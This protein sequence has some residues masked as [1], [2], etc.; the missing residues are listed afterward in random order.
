MI[1]LYQKIITISLGL[2][3][4]FW[5][6][7]TVFGAT[8]PAYVWVYQWKA[9]SGVNTPIQTSTFETEALC[10]ADLN[11]STMYSKTPCT[12]T[13]NEMATQLNTNEA[14]RQEEIAARVALNTE[15]ELLKQINCNPV[16][17]WIGGVFGGDGTFVDCISLVTYY[18]VYKPATW[19][20]IIAGYL[21]DTSIALSIDTHFVNQ[22]FVADTWVV[23]RDFSNM[24]FIFILLYTGVQTILGL[25]NWRSTVL[26][27]IIM[28]L[29]I[30][31]SL[32]FT[33]VVIDAGNILAVGVYEAM[34]VVKTGPSAI[35][36]PG[37]PVERNLSES[38]VA[39]F[40]PQQFLSKAGKVGG[41]NST[42][43]FIVAA[44][45]NLFAAYVMFSVA[46]IFVGRLLAFWFLMI[47]SPFAFISIALPRGNIF[48]WWMSTLL[49]QSF[50]AP[51]F[52][53]LLYVLMKILSASGGI[54]QGFA[55]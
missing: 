29:L 9:D 14:Q 33:R 30:N 11:A 40:Q 1:K 52:L 42:I 36:K 6:V 44:I 46:L 26:R 50:V 22:P 2:V 20:L 7:S 35:L 28:A 54:L 37:G 39:N 47:A 48:D 18:A 45:V 10:R 24:L 25:G 12:M 5:G 49:N 41:T 31:F 34:G 32:F 55:G 3:F 43:I 13:I 51:V 15:D 23:V 38:L 53:F 17:S 4:F 21:F 16:G 27:V 8:E 19:L